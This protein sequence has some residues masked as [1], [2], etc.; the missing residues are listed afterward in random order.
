MKKAIQAKRK[1][2]KSDLTLIE[3]GQ[4]MHDNFVE[5]KDAFE[6]RYPFMDDAYATAWQDAI[7]IADTEPDDAEVVGEQK[8]KTFAVS[9]TMQLAAEKYSILISFLRM[10]Y[11]KNAGRVFTHFGFKPNRRKTLSQ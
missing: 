9:D 5:D 8:Q 3:Q 7:T 4:T 11:K 10:I 2:S 6:A 1:Y